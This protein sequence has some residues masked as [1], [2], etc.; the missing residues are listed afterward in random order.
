MLRS[1][2]PWYEYGLTHLTNL[3]PEMPC[4]RFEAEVTSVGF[5]LHIPHS[6]VLEAAVIP[7]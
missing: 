7:R 4:A 2:A 1:D 3:T 5:I 6:E